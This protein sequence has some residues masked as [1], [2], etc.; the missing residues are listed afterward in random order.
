MAHL[1]ETEY[2]LPQHGAYK[3]DSLLGDS[4]YT[5]VD[6]AQATPALLKI[7]RTLATRRGNKR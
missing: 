1:P 3:I 6:E 7:D 2:Y 4:S 5:D